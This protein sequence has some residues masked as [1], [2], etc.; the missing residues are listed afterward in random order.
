MSAY[1]R[2][3]VDNNGPVAQN[4]QMQA[5]VGD[6]VASLMASMVDTLMESNAARLAMIMSGIVFTQTSV[7]NYAY[8]LSTVQGL[9][10]G[11][12]FG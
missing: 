10:D 4:Y 5:M 6:M 3:V 8:F 2:P 12:F 11:G 1:S 9:L 7:L